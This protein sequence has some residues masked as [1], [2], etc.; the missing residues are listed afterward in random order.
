[1]KVLKWIG[2]V[3]GSLLLLIVV[4][5][6]FLSP[7]WRVERSVVVL[8]PPAAIHPYVADLAKWKDWSPF[9]HEDPAMTLE[10]S[11]PSEGVGAW[12]SWKSEKMGNGRM[13]IVST[14]PAKG[15]G[16]KL[17]MEG[18]DPFGIDFVYEAAGDGATKVTWID[19]GKAGA[20]PFHRWMV[21]A[22][23]SMMGPYFE[24]GLVSLKDL[25]EKGAPPAK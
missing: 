7:E 1:M 16:M 24:R 25:S 6:F 18:W 5:G 23:D 22:M 9:D 17:T 19:T 4:V 21:L 13:D 2:I 8:A 12:R 11:S 3:V 15:V 14:D 20:N 10:V